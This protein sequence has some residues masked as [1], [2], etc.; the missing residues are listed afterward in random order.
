MENL[1]SAELQLYSD[2]QETGALVC[3]LEPLTPCDSQ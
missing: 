3:G 1:L 2:T